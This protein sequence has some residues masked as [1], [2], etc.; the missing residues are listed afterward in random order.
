M[1]KAQVELAKDIV[2]KTK[3]IEVMIHMLPGVGVSEDEQVE[4]LRAL[5]EQLRAA[6]KER[7]EEAQ[8]REE[9]LR[10]VQETVGKLRRV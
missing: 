1:R 6:E 7:E 9:V 8:K 4:R 5:E 2:F 3:Q 10:R